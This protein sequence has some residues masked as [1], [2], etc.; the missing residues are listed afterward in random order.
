MGPEIL[1]AITCGLASGA[2]SGFMQIMCK[3]CC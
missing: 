3:A 1:I 2:A